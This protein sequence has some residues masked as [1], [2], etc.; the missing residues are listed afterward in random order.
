MY[1]WSRPND[2]RHIYIA[3]HH[4]LSFLAICLAFLLFPMAQGA[5]RTS[6]SRMLQGMINRNQPNT[7]SLSKRALYCWMLVTDEEEIF[8]RI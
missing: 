5:R 6:N 7:P 2:E 3:R 4:L 1:R 8:C